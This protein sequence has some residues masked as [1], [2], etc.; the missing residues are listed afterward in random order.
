MYLGFRLLSLLVLHPERK[1]LG[2][3]GAQAVLAS[4]RLL[5][6]PTGAQSVLHHSCPVAH[7]VVFHAWRIGSSLVNPQ[8]PQPAESRPL[9]RR[10]RARSCGRPPRDGSVK[11]GTVVVAGPCYVLCGIRLDPVALARSLRVALLRWLLDRGVPATGRTGCS[12][13]AV[14]EPS[15]PSRGVGARPW[16]R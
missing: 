11:P 15:Q 2:W 9:L 12:V 14:L 7:S 13:T 10:V 4:A 6:H 3:G 16:G 1:H 5:E 8:L